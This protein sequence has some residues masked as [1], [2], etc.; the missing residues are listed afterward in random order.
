M[1]N[2]LITFY[3]AADVIGM[4]ETTNETEVSAMMIGYIINE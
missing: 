1:V 2:K 3:T 4:N